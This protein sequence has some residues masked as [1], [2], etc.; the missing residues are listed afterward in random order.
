M[1]D[2]T[3]SPVAV[4]TGASSGIGEATARALAED[5]YRLA[6]L[7]RRADRVESLAEELGNGALAVPA[8]VPDRASLL[9]AAGRSRPTCSAR[10][11]PPRSSSTS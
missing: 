9:A 8:D 11:L 2:N 10:S 3:D 5:G 4:L 6:L 1:P 7:A